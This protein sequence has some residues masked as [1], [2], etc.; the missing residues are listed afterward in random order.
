MWLYA[1]T[2]KLVT[3][4]DNVIVGSNVYDQ[5]ICKILQISICIVH[6]VKFVA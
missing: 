1:Q 6:M 4:V 5:H 3:N 2:H